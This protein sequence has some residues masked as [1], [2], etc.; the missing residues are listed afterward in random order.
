MD[1]NVHLE[2]VGLLTDGNFHVA[3]SIAEVNRQLIFSNLEFYVID[4]YTKLLYPFTV[5]NRD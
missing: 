2:I 4:M 5:Y 1:S 3:K